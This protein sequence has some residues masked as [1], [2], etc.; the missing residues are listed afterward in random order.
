MKPSDFFIKYPKINEC[1]EST[2]G[3]LHFNESDAILHSSI[4]DLSGQLV[5]HVRESD[6]IN[7]KTSKKS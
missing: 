4:R 2:D 7:Q 6:P 1:W 5:R 3:Q